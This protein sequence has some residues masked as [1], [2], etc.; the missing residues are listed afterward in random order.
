[1]SAFMVPGSAL[2]LLNYSVSRKHSKAVIQWCV[3]ISEILTGMAFAL[4]MF[5][6]IEL[7]SLIIPFLAECAVLIAVAFTYLVLLKEHAFMILPFAAACAADIA[8]FM[9]TGSSRYSMFVLAW[10]IIF[11]V[12]SLSRLIRES[13]R[14]DDEL[15][16]S[17]ITALMNQ[18]RPHFVHNTLTSV[19]Y[20]CETDPSLAQEV[21]LNFTKYLQGNFRSISKKEPVPFSDELE[22]VQAYIAVEQA[23]FSGELEIE[24]DTGYT[25][26]RLPALTLQPI[27]ENSVKHGV[28]KGISPEK[29][30]IRTRKEN[31]CA[32]ISVLDNGPGF[33]PS[34]MESAGSRETREGEYHTG[35][36]NVRDRLELM[37]GGK[38]E[39]KNRP[40]G[41]CEVVVTVPEKQ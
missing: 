14:K 30:I 2:T 28:G 24:Y 4:Q 10:I 34:A 11:S 36:R 21:L 17:R 22:Q 3:V 6:V 16:E 37:C 27:V 20:L 13:I 12:V 39:I 25:G 7:H 38:L 5:Q 35:L 15:R 26:F 9:I 1:M 23:R 31:G 18:I 32:V 41:G 40:E 29:I 19:Y 8:V 33:D